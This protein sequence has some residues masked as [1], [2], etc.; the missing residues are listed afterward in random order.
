MT[1]QIIERVKNGL[2]ITILLLRTMTREMTGMKIPF[3]SASQRFGKAR[4]WTHG[5]LH[6]AYGR[7]SKNRKVLDSPK[8]GESN[9]MQ[10]S[11]NV[12]KRIKFMRLGLTVRPNLILF[13]FP[14]GVIPLSLELTTEGV[15]RGSSCN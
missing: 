8:T 5:V 6:E 11:P 2:W 14:E 4:A 15:V 9:K 3:E 1:N 7:G 13:F 12:P 10:S